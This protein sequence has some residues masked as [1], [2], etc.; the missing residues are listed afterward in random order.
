M[1]LHNPQSKTEKKS[2]IRN[3]CAAIIQRLQLY[4]TPAKK[5]AIELPV[6]TESE[7][8]NAS[9]RSQQST[10][11][12]ARENNKSFKEQLQL[13]ISESMN[14]ASEAPTRDVRDVLLNELA[15]AEC[16]GE[17]QIFRLSVQSLA[18]NSAYVC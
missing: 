10:E 11:E 1:Y 3:Y 6:E 18:D 9:E 17:R 8:L 14:V 5:A 13:A 16:T 2:T 4:G 12:A 15:I 7:K